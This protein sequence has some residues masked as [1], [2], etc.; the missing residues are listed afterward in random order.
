[1]IWYMHKRLFCRRETTERQEQRLGDQLRGYCRRSVERNGARPRVVL[2]AMERSRWF[3]GKI[4]QQIWKP[5]KWPQDWISSAFIP[6]SKKGNAKECTNYCKIEVISKASKEMLKIP[7]ARL[8]RYMNHELPDVQDGFR[9]GREPQ[10]KL[11]TSAGS[12]KKEDNS[13][14]AST[15]TLLTTPEPLTV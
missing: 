5:Q 15:S 2:V 14:K 7:L 8:Q 6:I 1:M 9:K 4:C 11:P 12:L 10:T 3:L 13:R